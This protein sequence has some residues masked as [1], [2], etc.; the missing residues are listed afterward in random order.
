MPPILTAQTRTRR[1]KPKATCKRLRSTTKAKHGVLLY[2]S[3]RDD[4]ATHCA[5]VPQNFRGLHPRISL[6]RIRS[7]PQLYCRPIGI[8][9]GLDTGYVVEL[10]A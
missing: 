4:R 7:H 6:A 2:A 5:K 8:W 3:S 10:R 1:G 9:V